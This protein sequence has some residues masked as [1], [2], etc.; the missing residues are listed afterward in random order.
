MLAMNALNAKLL[1]TML[2]S[3]VTIM[4]AI[5]MIPPLMRELGYQSA[6]IVLKPIWFAGK[7]R[8]P[9]NRSTWNR[10]RFYNHR[11]TYVGGH[12]GVRW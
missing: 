1:Y 8:N 11:R 4:M 5:S 6:G 7:S 9:H 12:R 2:V 3:M 10:I